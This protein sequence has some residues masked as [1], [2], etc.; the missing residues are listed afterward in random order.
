MATD[1]GTT[2][3]SSDALHRAPG[4][5][6]DAGVRSTKNVFDLATLLGGTTNLALAAKI[7]QG[8]EVT[9]VLVA[10]TADASGINLK[11]GTSAD[12]D[13]YGASAAGPNATTKEW[14]VPIATQD[15]AAL[16][17]P[18]DILITPSGNWPASG[19]LVTRIEYTK[20]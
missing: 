20:R 17:A 14:L 15:D 8:C 16:S 10:C 7:P 19:T 3:S 12:D 9:R 2:Y 6:A 13:K 4:T 18:E 5:R 1:Y 11:I